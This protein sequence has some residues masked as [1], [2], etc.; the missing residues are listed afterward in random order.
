[1][2]QHIT[3]LMNEQHR[4]VRKSPSSNPPTAGKDELRNQ[5]ASESGRPSHGREKWTVIPDMPYAV[6]QVKPTGLPWNASYRIS[7]IPITPATKILVATPLVSSYQTI[8][9]R[10]FTTGAKYFAASNA[11]KEIVFGTQ[12]RKKQSEG[13]I[14]VVYIPTDYQLADLFTKPIGAHRYNFSSEIASIWLPLSS[15][16]PY[17]ISPFCY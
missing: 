6:G 16:N 5:E 11:T 3:K 10:S 15:F 13:V 2:T 8:M 17:D 12:S 9:H 7:Q 4:N 1:M 14:D